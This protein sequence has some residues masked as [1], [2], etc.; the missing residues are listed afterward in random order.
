MNLRNKKQLI[1]R[2]LKVG[3]NRIILNSEMRNEIKEAITRQDIK[4]LVK[5]GVI[6]I[7]EVKGRKKKVK[8]KTR[9]KIGSK[10]IIVKKRKQKHMQLVRKL[11][12]RIRSLK[13]RISKE[14]YVE[15]RKKVNS[16]NIKNQAHLEEL[17]KE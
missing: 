16:G 6:K 7:K 4:D 9:R 3:I 1:A 10:K 14:K 8:R 11:R 12:G 2:T 5:E 17:L 15:L 13:G